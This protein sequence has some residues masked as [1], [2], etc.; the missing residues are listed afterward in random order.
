MMQTQSLATTFENNAELSSNSSTLMLE[1][2]VPEG[3]RTHLVRMFR[4]PR[5]LGSEE[6]AELV[7]QLREAVAKEPNVSGLRVLL[8]MGLCVNLEVQ[9]AMEELRDAVRL[10]PDSFI[11]RLKLGELLMRLRVC[12]EAAEH[13]QIAAELADSDIQAELARRQATAIRTMRR[14]GVER[15]GSRKVTSALGFAT[16]WLSRSLSSQSKVALTSR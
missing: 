10:A 9:E 6:R 11:A 1:A 2:L 7:Q 3:A 13:T 14:E 8:G 5:V 15:G 4:D 16:R 12:T